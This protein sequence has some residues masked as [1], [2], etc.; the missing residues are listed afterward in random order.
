MKKYIL[1]ITLLFSI[2]FILSYLRGHTLTHYPIT[3]EVIPTAFQKI[4]G[5]KDMYVSGDFVI[6]KSNGLPDHKSPYYKSTAWE[7]EYYEPYQGKNPQFRLNPNR[8]AEESYTFRIPKNPTRAERTRATPLGP[9]GISLN[10]VPFFNQYAARRSSLTREVNS[11]DHYN[12]HPQFHGAYHYHIEPTY[13]TQTKGKDAL[14]GFLLDGF[15]VYGPIENGMPVTN[16][17]LDEYHGHS[18]TTIDYPKGIYHY[19]ITS[20]DPYINGSGFYG[21]PGTITH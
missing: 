12:G 10:G 16:D 6:I 17:M 1:P 20:T 15:P 11:F 5:A 19:H 9:I 3:D 2:V 13:L 4:Y 8:I 21:K 14:L 18:H 7:E